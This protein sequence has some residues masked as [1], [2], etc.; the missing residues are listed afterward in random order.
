MRIIH[1]ISSL[2][3][4]GA[5][6]M[7]RRLILSESK[8]N[9][10]ILIISLVDIGEIGLILQQAGFQ[11]H[12]I[13]FRKHAHLPLNLFKL[14]QTIRNFKPEIVQTWMYHADFFGGLASRIAGYRNIV[15]GIRS[16]FVPSNRPKTFM[17]MRLCGYLSFLIPKKIVC[18]AKSAQIEHAKHGYDINKMQV[19]H[20]GYDFH[21]FDPNHV[22]NTI[23]RKELCLASSELLIG[24]VGRFHID[25]GQDVFI[26]AVGL[27][28]KHTI[29]N[30]RFVLIGRKCD[31]YN[32]RIVDLLESLGLA[33]NFILLGERNDIPECLAAMDIFCMPSRTEGFPNAL[34][35]AMLMALPCV[36]TCVGDALELAGNAIE[37]VR[38]DDPE[39]LAISLSN[40]ILMTPE[41]R[42]LIGQNCAN[43]VRSNFS[44]EKARERFNTLY[45]EILQ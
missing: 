33:S 2:N 16:T 23:I 39:A 14:I 36:A 3:I 1:I 31:K 41:Q 40:M 28:S 22:N 9:A 25:K 30:V 38:P 12:A 7:L 27:L 15:W 6:Q 19:I 34:A 45:R 37:L 13:N 24:C 35:E 10:D 26:K 44:I 29:Q 17:I 42:K 32:S 11:V 43:Q 5:E 8:P 18:V 4:G 20:N 21:S